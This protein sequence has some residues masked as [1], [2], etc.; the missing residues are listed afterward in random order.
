VFLLSAPPPLIRCAS[1]LILAG[2]LAAMP[3]AVRA[4]RLAGPVPARVVAVVDGD[5]LEVQAQIWLGQFIQTKVRLESIDTPELRSSCELERT[6]AR[7]AQQ[8]LEVAIQSANSEIVL[9]N[10]TD[11]KFGGRVRA[12][13][14]LPDGRDLSDALIESGNA[15]LYSGG[16]RAAWC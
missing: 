11:D 4:E 10:V 6:K 8:F 5:T 1:R 14:L 9:L 7:T 12:R 2:L 15:R 3:Q 16:R 13:V